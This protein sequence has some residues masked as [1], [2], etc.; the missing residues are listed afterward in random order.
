MHRFFGGVV[1]ESTWSDRHGMASPPR[2]SCSG[3]FF[4]QS[5]VVAASSAVAPSVYWV[6][7]HGAPVVQSTDPAA[8]FFGRAG[9]PPIF[10]SSC[11]FEPGHDIAPGSVQNSMSVFG[12]Q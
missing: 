5:P 11:F 7:A 9:A 1:P 8:G 6:Q 2:P 4:W 3:S 10:A 12:P